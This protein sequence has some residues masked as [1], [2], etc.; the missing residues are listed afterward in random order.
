MD[1]FFNLG[2]L[3]KDRRCELKMEVFYR[4]IPSTRRSGWS[5]SAV[6]MLS[7]VI[8]IRRHLHGCH[9]PCLYHQSLL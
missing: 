6:M 3:N 4:K 1:N 9:D 7:C 2:K 8:A 5:V